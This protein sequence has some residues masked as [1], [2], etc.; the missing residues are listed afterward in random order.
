MSGPRLHAGYALATAMRCL[1][2]AIRILLAR[3]LLVFQRAVLAAAYCRFG[4]V[5]GV[6]AVGLVL[7][8]HGNSFREPGYNGPDHRCVP[9]DGAWRYGYCP[10]LV[11]RARR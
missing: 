3:T 7:L 2:A 4:G 9:G 8:R 5:L 10:K 11:A 1:V 6:L